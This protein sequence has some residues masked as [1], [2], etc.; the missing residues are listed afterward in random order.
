MAV[1]GRALP[2]RYRVEGPFLVK[3]AAGQP[4]F[5]L[6]VAGVRRPQRRLRREPAFYLVSAVRAGEGGA[7]PLPAEEL[8][9]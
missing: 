4:L 1:R 7:L 6:V 2:L 5:L 3:P 9:A 8:L